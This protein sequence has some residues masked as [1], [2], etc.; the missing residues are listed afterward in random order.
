ME[1]L[2]GI[3]PGGSRYTNESNTIFTLN[4]VTIIE[5]TFSTKVSVHQ[6][7]QALSAHRGRTTVRLQIGKGGHCT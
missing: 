6:E 7:G 5:P 1:G 2:L 3:G 4:K